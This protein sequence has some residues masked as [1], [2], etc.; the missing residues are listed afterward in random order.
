MTKFYPVVSATLPT[1]PKR[2]YAIPIFG[3]LLKML[4]L[5][6]VFIEIG[7]LSVALYFLSVVNSL[8]VL[9]TGKFW[10]PMYDLGLGLSNLIAR[11]LLFLSGITDKYPGFKI[12]SAG[13]VSLEKPVAPNRLFALPFL[14]G[15]VRFLLVIPYSIYFTI[16]SYASW[17]GTL[18]AVKFVLVNRVYPEVTFEI[19]LDSARV[20]LAYILYFFGFSDSYP[21]FKISMNHKTEKIILL[22]LGT[23]LFILS[24]LNGS[25]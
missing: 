11:N 6:P 1:N 24:N 21:S 19:A 3:F 15:F 10:D 9:F 8:Y 20:S 18:Y 12:E 4:M 14:G 16:I 17:F 22:V 2:L 5:L 23:I 7:F 13:P 25:R